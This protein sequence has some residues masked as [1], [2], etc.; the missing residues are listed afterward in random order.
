MVLE[1]RAATAGTHPAAPVLQAHVALGLPVGIDDRRYAEA[2]AEGDPDVRTQAGAG[3]EPDAVVAVGGRGWRPHQVAAEFTHVTE[4]RDA[5]AAHVGEELA[6]AEAS[7]RGEAGA[8]MERRR[9]ADEVGV[10][11]VERRRGV[12]A[13]VLGLAEQHRQRAASGGEFRVAHD[14]WLGKAGRTGGVDVEEDVARPDPGD[15]GLGRAG[16]IERLGERAETAAIGH[17]LGNVGE[18]IDPAQAVE[19]RQQGSSARSVDD[20][21]PRTRHTV[22]VDERLALEMRIHQRRDRAELRARALGHEHARRVLHHH[23]DDVAT[24]DPGAAQHVGPAIHAG[25]ELAVGH[26]AVL[27]AQGDPVGNLLGLLPA[28]VAHR[29]K[30]PGPRALEGALHL[31]KPRQLD[32]VLEEGQGSTGQIHLG[33]ARSTSPAARAASGP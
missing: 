17:L 11:V 30:R 19:E 29:P 6:R 14:R 15:V 1:G 12:G 22:H 33:R 32:E 7:P 4:D 20:G 21:D 8:A 26:G 2:L 16:G 18:E 10:A 27:E 24:A 5:V 13:I 3:R 31:E 25:V 9:E 28:D 23:V